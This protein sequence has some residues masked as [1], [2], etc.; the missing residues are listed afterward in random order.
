M[1]DLNVILLL[2]E[3]ILLDKR[4][5]LV[6]IPLISCLRVLF[7]NVYR[8]V[9]YLFWGKLLLGSIGGGLMLAA[10]CILR[11]LFHY[12][13]KHHAQSFYLRPCNTHSVVIF[14]SIRPRCILRQ[15]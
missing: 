1:F 12:F 6:K 7:K 13:F 4:Y 2:E 11:F 10:V 3:R 8:I 5:Q 14:S 9:K 15:Y